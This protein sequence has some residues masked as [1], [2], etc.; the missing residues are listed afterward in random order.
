MMG[1][2]NFAHAWFYMLGAY[3]GFTLTRPVG[4]FWI[5][6]HPRAHRRRLPP[7]I[8]VERYLLRRVHHYGHAHE[9]LLTFGL[10]FIIEEVIEL[11]IRRLLGRRR[12]AV[13]ELDHLFDGEGEAEREQ[14]LVRVPDLCTRRRCSARP[15]R[16]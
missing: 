16:R 4:E 13:E 3:V 8:L 1:V 12:V 10:A 5:G 6:F 15:G 9:L 11:F 14:Q 2:L 7:G